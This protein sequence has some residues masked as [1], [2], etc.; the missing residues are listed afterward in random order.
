MLPGQMTLAN[1]MSQWIALT[2]ELED[3][4][5]KVAKHVYKMF[6]GGKLHNERCIDMCRKLDGLYEEAQKFE[7]ELKE[8]FKPYTEASSGGKTFGKAAAT[9]AQSF[10]SQLYIKQSVASYKR[11]FRDAYLELGSKVITD[12]NDGYNLTDDPTVRKLCV[13]AGKVSKE[14]NERWEE[15]E[16]L[17]RE[18]V[19]GNAFL[20]SVQNFVTNLG[21]WGRN[22]GIPLLKNAV[23]VDEGAAKKFRDEYRKKFMGDIKGT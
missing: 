17:N 7:D 13:Y 3:V 5:E 14:C 8:D 4:K 12:I 23:K 15:I 18:N 6:K 19:K 1:Q 22:N 2:G 20:A 21:I 9:K 10:L 16:I 11:H